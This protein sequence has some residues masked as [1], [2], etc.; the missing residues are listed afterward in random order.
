[1]R[2]FFLPQ[3]GLALVGNTFYNQHKQDVGMVPRRAS[4][5]YR[6]ACNVAETYSD[7]EFLEYLVKSL[8]DN[9][10]AVKV[11]RVVDEMGV[12]LT[13]DIDPQWALSAEWKHRK[14]IA[15]FFV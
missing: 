6:I 10:D 13:L 2:G 5:I 1:M 9:P 12:L 3:A 8:V 15:R 14:A 4:V 11:T 7:K